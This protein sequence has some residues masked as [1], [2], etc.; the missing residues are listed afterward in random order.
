MS[1]IVLELQQ[2]LLRKDCDILQALRK[3]HVIAVKLKLTDIDIWIRNEL[4]GYS[5]SN[6][7]IPEYRNIQ[8]I[9]KFN[10]PVHGWIS[11]IFEDKKEEDLLSHRKLY[12]PIGEIIELSKGIESLFIP[13][14]GSISQKLSKNAGSP[15]V[16]EAALFI[17]KAA[18]NSVVEKV[19]NTLLEWTLE[20]E[21][22][23]ILG[24]GMTFSDSEAAAAK[25]FPQQINYYGT[26]VN[27]NIS[28]SQIASGSNNSLVYNAT[29]LRDAVC[30]IRKTLER[31]N[32]SKDDMVS[33]TELLEDITSKIEQKK[34]PGI[35][36]AALVGLKDF[37]LT[38][39]ANVTATLIAAKIQGLF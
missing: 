31:E 12:Q 18:V 2:E 34:K 1:S 13:F 28:G 3:A 11:L 27:G 26:V 15:V 35:I 20:L 7:N 39:G 19:K 14:P 33:A 4:N 29:E 24:D 6:D 32:L 37:A 30:E 25:R 17:T 36:K 16:L 8:G 21:E 23:G 5:C 38:V 10:N 22:S 9:V